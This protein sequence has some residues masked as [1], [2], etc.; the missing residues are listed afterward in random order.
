[1]PQRWNHIV[2]KK[3]S[4]VRKE[5]AVRA[6]KA[7]AA[8]MSDEERSSTARGAALARWGQGKNEM[9]RATHSGVIRVGEIELPCFV[10]EDGTRVL[11]GRGLASAFGQKSSSAAPPTAPLDDSDSAVAGRQ[12]PA[13]LASKSVFPFLSNDLLLFA[14]SPVRFSNPRGGGVGHGYNA[15][16]LP[17]ICRSILEAKSKG[18]LKSNQMAMAAAAEILIF[19]LAKTGIVALVDEATGYQY[20]RA[21]D[22]LQK[23]LEAY[24]AEELRPWTKRFSNTFFKEVYRLHGWKFEPGV[25]QGPRYVGKFINKHVYEQLPNGVLEELRKR[26]PPEDNGRRRHK[27][28]QLLTEDTGDVHLDGQILKLTTLMQVARTKEEFNNMFSRAFP[29][30]GQQLTLDGGVEPEE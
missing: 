19:A 26:N 24:I 22:E 28:F 16:I 7:R 18:A 4:R 12:V 27:H 30:P 5:I 13:F 11:S 29:R 17:E 1:M 2:T 25:T 20:D 9:V 10:L 15:T 3:K 6:G 8:S 21:R 23:I 14:N